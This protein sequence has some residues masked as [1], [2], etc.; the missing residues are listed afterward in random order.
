MDWA[1]SWLPRD[2]ES[3]YHCR[4]LNETYYL[5][6][7]GVLGVF[8]TCLTCPDNPS[9]DAEKKWC[10]L[11]TSKWRPYHLNTIDDRVNFCPDLHHPMSAF[12]VRL[13]TFGFRGQIYSVPIHIVICKGCTVSGWMSRMEKIA[14]RLRLPLVTPWFPL[15]VRL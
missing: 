9:R 12:R 14:V 2:R 6:L 5:R 8:E 13:T 1:L 10:I 11:V 3:G 4:H 7:N 15:D